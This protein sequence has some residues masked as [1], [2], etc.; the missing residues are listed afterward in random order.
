MQASPPV[1]ASR[2]NASRTS[3]QYSKSGL[4][5]GLLAYGLWGVLPLYFKAI[6]TVAPFDIVAHRVLW[7]LPFLALL[8][9]ISKGLGKV[10]KA[11]GEPRTLGMLLVTALLIGANWLLYVF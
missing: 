8:I 11:I 6:A 10:R 3:A 7:S 1:G 9:C 5:L 2:M 4:A